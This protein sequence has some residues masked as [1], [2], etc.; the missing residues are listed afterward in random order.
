MDVAMTAV[1]SFTVPVRFSPARATPS[2]RPASR[3]VVRAE[4]NEK[5]T[6]GKRGDQK[7]PI[8]FTTPCPGED[9]EPDPCDREKQSCRQFID[10]YRTKCKACNG[11]GTV[12][13]RAWKSKK[14][15]SSTVLGTCL[16]C[17]GLGWVRYVEA[18]KSLPYS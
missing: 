7:L 17:K 14:K 10:V 16:L 4:R 6:F 13:S 11:S 15:K 12:Y 8:P 9:E 2:R 18:D 5:S 3:L 1:L